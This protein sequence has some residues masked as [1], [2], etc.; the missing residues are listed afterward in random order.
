MNKN[1][2]NEF[3]QETRYKALFID[4]FDEAIVGLICD[5]LENPKVVYSKKVIFQKLLKENNLSVSAIAEKLNFTNQ[6]YFSRVFK[7]ITGMT[8]TEF[9]E[10]LDL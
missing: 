1:Q 9:K 2:I 8:P 5:G 7:R 6:Y 4:G 3:L 10:T